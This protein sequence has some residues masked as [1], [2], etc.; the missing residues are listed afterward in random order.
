[1]SCQLENE[2]INQE[3]KR[4]NAKPKKKETREAISE[5]LEALKKRKT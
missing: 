5:Q 1:M 2:A 4:L 3:I